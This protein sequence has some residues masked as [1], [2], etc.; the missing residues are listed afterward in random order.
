MFTRVLPAWLLVLVSLVVV[1]TAQAALTHDPSLSWRTIHT[2]HF[3]VHFHDGGEAV[4]Q[5]TAVLAERVHEKLVPLIGWTPEGPVDVVVDG[6]QDV[7]NGFASFFPSNR[8]T[9]FVTPPDE[10]NSL[11]DHDGWL[12][13]V[14]THEYVHILHLDRAEG[15]PAFLRKVFGRSVWV[16]PV[17]TAFPNLWQPRWL[18][19]GLAT[20]HET[21]RQRGIGR[22]QSSYFDMLMRMEVA[23][24][25]KPVYQVN[26][27]MASWPAGYVPYLYGVAFYDFVAD[28]K[29]EDKVRKLIDE[30]SNDFVPLFINRNSRKALGGKYSQL[31]KEFEDYLKERHG[32]RLEAIR[33]QGVVAGEQVTHDGYYGGAARALP[34][35]DLVYLRVD[36]RNEPALMQQDRDGRIHKLARVAYGTH[37]TVHPRGGA[38]I[39]QPELVRNSNLYYDL[40]RIDLGSG[41]CKRLTRSG[42]YRFAAFSP[43]AGRIA[44]VR[45]DESGRHSLHLLDAAGKRLE[46]LWAGE[47]DVTLADPDWSPDGA[48]I[49]MA[50]FRPN[51]GWNLERFR[52]ADRQFERLTRDGEIEMHPVHT[53]DGK[54][55]LFT[56]DHGGVYNL[57]RLDLVSGR[58]TTLTNVEGGA[59]HPTQ[60]AIDGPIY[61]TGNH[62]AGFDIY[63][64]DVPADRPLPVSTARPPEPA[65]EVPVMA[66][67]P[68]I[69]DYSPWS[70]LRPR[71]W[72]PHLL[73][74]SRRTEVGA[75]TSG[76][77]VLQRHIYYVDAAYDFHNEWFAGSVDYIYD[78]FDP[79]FKLHA[80]RSSS[81]FLDV[82]DDPA[83]V[84][85]SDTFMGE[86]MLP[87]ERYWRELT[88][89]A[90]AY[91]VHDSDGWVAA[92]IAPGPN[93]RDNVL[94]YALTYDS[95]Q[96]YPRSISRSHGLQLSLSAETSDAFDNSSYSGE[97]YVF[98][99]RVFLPLGLEHVLAVRA[100]YGYGTNNPRPFILGG[101]RTAG[102]T[103]YPLDPVLLSSPFNQREFA[104]RGYESGEAGLVGRRMY[105]ASLEWRFPLWR[106]ERGLMAPPVSIHQLY[107]S[108]F[109][110]MGDAWQDGR[111]PDERQTG[112]GA[113]LNAEIFLG[114]D[115]GLH[116]RLGYAYG[117]ANE[118][119]SHVYLQLGSSF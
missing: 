9:I 91:Q 20:W 48:S 105:T 57:R 40:Y 19:E 35:G 111:S 29:G 90:A 59:F 75:T 84:T 93:R 4:A 49:V 101:S 24:G 46:V 104:L 108:A 80:S 103:P 98:D 6:R 17:F 61:Y 5:R 83:R 10:L 23:S 54:A 55:L 39:A 112:A 81:L 85:T 18:I 32:T 82:Y 34:N 62:P 1:S 97:V 3:R 11:E 53:A 74:D 36:G 31:W 71:W 70:S 21:D 33:Q 89:R 43:D 86:V 27:Y 87:F 117:F 88:L 16:L 51:G 96:R 44:A 113:E 38:L 47:P 2:R 7:T 52:I 22:G 76:W 94:G 68:V 60:A 63:R 109:A 64:L 8:M 79:V 110:E 42:R 25:I 45:N 65:A 115:L 26:Q 78:R 50:V 106:I 13:L 72:M 119:S 12:E 92:G 58:I 14:L 73:I 37:F 66:E 116:L 118:G 28:R 69:D 30:Y 100:T 56:S 99:G 95:T 102:V 107:G 77:D 41:R 15:G 114:Y 67:T